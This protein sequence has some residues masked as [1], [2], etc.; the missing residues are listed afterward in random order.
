MTSPMI[1]R[2]S[3]L[4]ARAGGDSPVMFSRMW[5]GIPGKSTWNS[6][7]CILYR[8]KATRHEWRQQVKEKTYNSC[9]VLLCFY[10]LERVTSL[11]LNW[12]TQCLFEVQGGPF[13]KPG[14]EVNSAET[15]DTN[16]VSSFAGDLYHKKE[17][18]MYHINNFSKL[19]LCVCCIV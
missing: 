19:I 11:T 18:C 9:G 8:T 12:P 3:S 15:W 7:Y 5:V 6:T 10:D 13:G 1:D 14:S 17:M 2:S 4:S 16:R